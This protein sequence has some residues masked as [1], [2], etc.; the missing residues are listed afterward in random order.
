MKPKILICW[1]FVLSF[2]GNLWSQDIIIK[3]DN[4]ELKTKVIEVNEDKI[5]YKSFDFLDGP[6]RSISTS[7][8]L[9]IIYQNGKRESFTAD[10]VLQSNKSISSFEKSNIEQQ[11]KQYS[12]EANRT[13]LGFIVGGKGGYFIPYDQNFSEIYGS[14]FMGG[15]VLGYWGENAAIDIDCRYFSKDGKPYTIGNVDYGSCH[16]NL[17]PLTFSGYWIPYSHNNFLIYIGAGLGACFIEESLSYSSMG[18]SGT[19]KASI[20]GHEVHTSGGIKFRPFY[21]E[22]IFSSIGSKETEDKDFGGIILSF[23]LFF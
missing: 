17:T 18:Q 9:M 20:T 5:V 6:L 21:V 12:A 10:R 7:N 11:E 15:L 14:G 22:A 19:V 4:S 1:L 3:K 16:M 23:G 13:K 2:I 8:V